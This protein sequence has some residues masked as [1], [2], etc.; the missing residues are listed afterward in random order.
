M[1]KA[2]M[3][4]QIVYKFRQVISVERETKRELDGNA[5]NQKHSNISE[6]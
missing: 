1:L 4:K 2:L 5:R 6:E 3:E